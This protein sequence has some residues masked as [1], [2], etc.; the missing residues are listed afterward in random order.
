M[1]LMMYT[2]P[3]Q[4]SGVFVWNNKQLLFTF[5]STGFLIQTILLTSAMSYPYFSTTF[6]FF[7][8]KIIF[9]N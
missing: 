1:L 5:R 7:I 8:T 9:S 6:P 3:E 4:Y 2:T